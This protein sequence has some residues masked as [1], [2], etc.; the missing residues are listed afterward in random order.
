MNLCEQPHQSDT[1][2]VKARDLREDDLV[3]MIESN[4]IHPF[5]FNYTDE[6][7]EYEYGNVDE[8][9]WEG[10]NCVVISFANLT[11]VAVSPEQELVIA[12][13]PVA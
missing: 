13:R 4:V 6:L 3:D 12:A 8:I 11:A 10:D 5:P 9:E 1:E 7:A 2:I